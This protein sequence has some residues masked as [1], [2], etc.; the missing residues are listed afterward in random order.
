MSAT[1]EVTQADRD[2][3]TAWLGY[4]GREKLSVGRLVTRDGLAKA[5]ARHRLASQQPATVG[6]DVVERVRKAI[7]DEMNRTGPFA[8]NAVARA[9]IAALGLTVLERG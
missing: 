6:E 2:A 5:F 7:M 1:V 3:A 8:S 4:S 9:A